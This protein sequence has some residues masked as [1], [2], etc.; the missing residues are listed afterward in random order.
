LFQ[1]A[2]VGNSHDLSPRDHRF[3]HRGL[4]K[5]KDPIDQAPF[6][7]VEVAAF[8]RDADQLS[9]LFLRVDRR[10]LAV[11]MQSEDAYRSRARPIESVDER[12]EALTKELRWATPRH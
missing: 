7:F 5:L 8:L 9:D 1:S 4:G 11:G 2:C 12:L 10:V 6:F 3:L